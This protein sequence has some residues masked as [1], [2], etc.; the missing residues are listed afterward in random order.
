MILS[1]LLRQS[2]KKDP[3]PPTQPMNWEMLYPG[4]DGSTINNYTAMQLSAV[5]ACIRLLSETLAQLPLVIRKRTADGSE[6][7]TGHPLWRLLHDQP[8]ER[9]TSFTW[10]NTQ[11]SHCAGWG[12]GYAFLVRNGKREVTSILPTR[13]DMTNPMIM[14]D[15]SIIYNMQLDNQ[16]W[17]ADPE[18]VLH[19]PAL[20]FDGLVG[21]SPISQHRQTLELT[22]SAEKFGNKMYENGA[23]LSGV[24]STDATLKRKSEKPGEPSPAER[25]AKQFKQAYSGVDNAGTV[26]V[27]EQG[28]KFQPISINPEDAQYLESRKFQIAEIARI[29]NVP[30]HLINDLD[31][32]TFNNISELSLSFLRYSM[33]PWIVRWEQELNRKLFPAGSKYYV[34][35]NVNG[36]LRGTQ[37]ERAEFYESAISKGCWMSRNEARKLED[38]N[39]IDGLDDYL[40]PL[41]MGSSQDEP[42]PND[43]E[44]NE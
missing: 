35:F 43:G 3:E 23:V 28:L 34:K 32:A 14:D 26:A 38:L 40:Q 29:F 44:S 1:S 10:R 27:L 21:Q 11:M 15:R 42:D 41:N 36:L 24:L 31:R 13:P 22:H 39:S 20:S 6:L 19:I 2:P 17:Q 37:K 5:Y 7:A 30:S 4:C 8:N 25:L 18:D 16:Y 9:M 12:N 33:T